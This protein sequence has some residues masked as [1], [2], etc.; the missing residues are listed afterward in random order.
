MRNDSIKSNFS[1][2]NYISPSK[3]S[4]LSSEEKGGD[5]SDEGDPSSGEEGCFPALTQQGAPKPLPTPPSPEDSSPKKKAR[6]GDTGRSATVVA[7]PSSKT[8]EKKKKKK[9]K[10]TEKTE[11]SVPKKP[12][13]AAKTPPA[14]RQRRIGF[15]P[16]PK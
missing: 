9:A 3:F 10:A 1:K 13:V 12:A 7:S 5:S 14:D 8:K 2:E 4:S 6:I 16:T 11:N 15:S